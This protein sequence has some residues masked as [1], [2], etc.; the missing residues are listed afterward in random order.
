MNCELKWFNA[1]IKVPYFSHNTHTQPFSHKQAQ[2]KPIPHN[3]SSLSLLG[4]LLLG[5]W[6]HPLQ[7]ICHFQQ[8]SRS[9]HAQR[10]RPTPLGVLRVWQWESRRNLSTSNEYSRKKKNMTMKEKLNSSGRQPKEGVC[11][12]NISSNSKSTHC[13]LCF[14]SEIIMGRRKDKQGHASEL[15]ITQKV[16]NAKME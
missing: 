14:P 7:S 12:A 4:C 16:E 6:A 10:N 2:N 8:K 9:A 11:V 13:V 15:N 1:R 5:G 3:L